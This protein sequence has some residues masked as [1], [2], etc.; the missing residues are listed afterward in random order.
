MVLVLNVGVSQA[1]SNPGSEWGGMT[2]FP[3]VK[4]LDSGQGTG[5]MLSGDRSSE[6]GVLVSPQVGDSTWG[7]VASF[8]GDSGSKH[9]ESESLMQVE[10][11][12][13]D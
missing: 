13:S 11:S 3:Q 7:E 5:L 9:D 12:G 1:G 4:D 2:L 10:D 6:W 8:S